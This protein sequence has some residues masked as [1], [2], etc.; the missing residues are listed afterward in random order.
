M[1]QSRMSGSVLLVGSIPGDNAADVLGSCGP[2]VGSYVTGLPDGETGYRRMWI[3][4]LA[5]KIFDGHPALETVQRPQPVPGQE[6]WHAD[7]YREENWL[8]KVKDGVEDLHFDQLGYATEAQHSYQ[9]FC[10]L[11]AEGVIPAGVR[12][13]VSL[14]LTESAVRGWLTNAHDYDLMRVA[15]EEAMGREIAQLL[16]AI[17]ADDLVIQWDIC[18]EV[19]ALALQ[20]Q[21][22]A[23]WQPPGDPFERYLQA[24]TS[25]A[26]HVPDPTLMGC[27]LC[28]GD[29]GHTHLVEP[30]DLSLVV[31]MANAAT[32]AVSR[33]IDFYH[34][35]VPQSR[36]DAAYFE[37]LT[38]LEIDAAKLYLGL[39]HLTGGVA[40]TVR[41]IRTA[42]HA[43]SS[44]G[45]ATECGLGCRPRDTLP[46]LYRIH[47]EAAAALSA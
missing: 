3:H 34:M 8:F 42:Q 28:Y 40:G 15:Y 30:P 9:D 39:V 20:D 16:S 38:D 10:R 32:H 23:P 33:P 27:H 17:P 29:L 37:P 35:P 41:R 26:Q 22:G 13:Q 25:M 7:D 21:L 1:A 4:F 6:R 14:P 36:D 11:R 44:F 5:V 43:Y 18:V 24:L 46:A 31:R 2:G 45:V 47:R 12:F 19:L